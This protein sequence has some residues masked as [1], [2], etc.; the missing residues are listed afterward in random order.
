M[1][2]TLNI[3][4]T[5][6]GGDIGQSVGKILSKSKYAKNVYGIDISDRN[7]AQFVFD[8][9]DIGPKVS[10][11][12]YVKDIETY[13]LKNEIDIIIPVSEHE[14]RFYTDNYKDVP[15]IGGAE[16]LMAN[17]FSRTIGFNKTSTTLFLKEN[18]LPNPILYTSSSTDI[19]FPI[20]AK[21]NTGAGSSNIFVVDN[22]EEFT[23][24][25]NKN[26]DFI[27]QELLDGKEGE[28]TCCA[29]RTKKGDIRNIIFKRE[30]TSGGYSG[31]GEVIE[32]QRIDALLIEIA[33]LLNLEGSIN[34][35]LRIHNEK[36]VVFEINPRFSST[37]L[38]R[39]L[40]GFKDLEWS[41]QE[42]LGEEISNYTKPK[43][44]KCFYKGYNEYIA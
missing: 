10:D 28:F 42:F 40:L 9:F 13:V 41:I 25:A 12:N 8:N 23:F 29:Y 31:Y 7:A 24:L 2:K 1:N 17:H 30:L 43:A 5:G 44:G 39:D 19:I 34:I 33:E 26:Q 21:P 15:V 32:D 14:L 37:I 11:E 4:I 22:Y 35:Q 36:P 38:F 16:V 6:C 18:K 27:F 3:L 20:I